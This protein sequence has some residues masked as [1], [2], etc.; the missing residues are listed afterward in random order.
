METTGIN[1]VWNKHCL[2]T[3]GINEKIRK[4]LAESMK[5]WRVELVS[6]EENLGEV[7]T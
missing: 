1:T 4:L 2:E 3:V 6:V 7:L 5:S